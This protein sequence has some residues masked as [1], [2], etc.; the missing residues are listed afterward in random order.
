METTLYNVSENAAI[1]EITSESGRTMKMKGEVIDYM[2]YS[3]VLKLDLRVCIVD[4]NANEWRVNLTS[5]NKVENR[6]IK[7][8]D[9]HG[10][11]HP[12]HLGLSSRWMK[13]SKP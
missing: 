8:I 9:K 7:E 4:L 3:E 12:T 13:R 1:H 5:F 2:P 6:L 11:Q 10:I